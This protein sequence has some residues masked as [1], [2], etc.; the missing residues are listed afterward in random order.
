MA[1]IKCP[2]CRNMLEDN[3]DI[4]P[5]CGYPIKKE[6]LKEKKKKEKEK[7]YLQNIL[8]Y[9]KVST[10]IFFVLAVIFFGKG[11]NVKN[12]Y[13]NS[14]LSETLNKNAY[15]GGDA[16]NYI[17]NGTYF[18]GYAI[19]GVGCLLSGII[20]IGIIVIVTI[21]IKEYEEIIIESVQKKNN[22]YIVYKRK[23]E[24]KN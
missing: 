16:Y 8:Y 22:G 1:L 23:I 9:L 18:T 6:L 3:K 7:P 11:Y 21:K 13:Y 24:K 14:E 15:V 19:I 10:V 5:N 4:C 12:N 2:E 17:I 20:L